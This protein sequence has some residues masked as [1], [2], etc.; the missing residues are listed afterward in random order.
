MSYKLDATTAEQIG[1]ILATKQ[2]NINEIPMVS[3]LARK[4]DEVLRAE[5]AKEQPEEA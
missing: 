2:F 3:E 4:V 1:H 5:K